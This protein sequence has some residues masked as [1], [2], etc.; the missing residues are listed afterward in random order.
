MLEVAVAERQQIMAR[1]KTQPDL[2]TPIEAAGLLKL[3]RQGIVKA[4]QRGDLEA[5][6]YGR[7]YLIDRSA[8]ERYRARRKPVG[9][10]RKTKR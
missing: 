6:R 3:T 7:L 1:K 9:R 8:L 2:L 5:R 10:P 4:I